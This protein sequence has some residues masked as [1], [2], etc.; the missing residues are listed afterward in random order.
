MNMG[1]TVV[2]R[3]GA[4]QI[5]RLSDVGQK[6]NHHSLNSCYSTIN[7]HCLKIEPIPFLLSPVR[8]DINSEQKTRLITRRAEPNYF[9]VVLL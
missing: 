4:V 2:S 3:A 6:E 9:E 5:A 1:T 8:A 7:K